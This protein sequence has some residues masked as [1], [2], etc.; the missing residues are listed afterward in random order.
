MPF[1]EYRATSADGCRHCRDGFTKL[2]KLAE[3]PLDACPGCGAPVERV[4]SAP[5]VV[6]GKAHMQRPDN[7][8]KHGFTQYKKIG[9]GVYEKTAG[10]GPR[11][12]KGD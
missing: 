11:I 1:Y 5:Q 7:I 10:T 3:E 9:Q 8:E 6:S 12:I 2:Q 4:I